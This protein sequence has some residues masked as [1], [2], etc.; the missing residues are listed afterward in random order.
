MTSE[1]IQMERVYPAGHQ[2]RHSPRLCSA[3]AAP[4]TAGGHCTRSVHCWRTNAPPSSSPTAARGWSRWSGPQV[5][6]EGD[7]D[8]CLRV[9]T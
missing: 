8:P 1:T 4:L 3:C 5:Y 7:A 6:E 2:E 9:R